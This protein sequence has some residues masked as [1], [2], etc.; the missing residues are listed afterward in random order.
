MKDIRHIREPYSEDYWERINPETPRRIGL[1]L[2]QKRIEQSRSLMDICKETRISVYTLESIE[3]G[4]FREVPKGIY[5]RSFVRNYARCL[6]IEPEIESFLKELYF[7]DAARLTT[8]H[9]A[10]GVT[11]E[12]PSTLVQH[13][14]PPQ[15]AEYILYLLL[16]KAERVYLIGDLTEE[17]NQVLEKFGAKRAKLWYHKQVLT[18]VSPLLY[19]WLTRL[20]SVVAVLELL[21]R[22]FRR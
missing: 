9:V 16:T 13:P 12:Y 20:K 22:L 1:R 11:R 5:F 4:A 18:S 21:E 10:E 19:R 15:F 14:T 3:S 2:K 7:D 8:I 6:Q 17:F